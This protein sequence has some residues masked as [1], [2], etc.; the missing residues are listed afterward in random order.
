MREMST[1][2]KHIVQIQLQMGCYVSSAWWS[3]LAALMP[4]IQRLELHFRT[5]PKKKSRDTPLTL[6]G[7]PNLTYLRITTTTYSSVYTFDEE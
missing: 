7:L 2:R 3:S 1:H 4:N 5:V 6:S